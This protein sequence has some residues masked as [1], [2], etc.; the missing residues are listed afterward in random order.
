MTSPFSTV[1]TALVDMIA[2]AVPAD[3]AVDLGPPQSESGTIAVTLWSADPGVPEPQR[4]RRHIPG[5][6]TFVASID[7]VGTDGLDLLHE[8]W[9]AVDA[10]PFDL[11]AQGPPLAWWLAHGVAPRPHLTIHAQAAVERMLTPA[12]LVTEPLVLMNNH[13]VP[14]R[15]LQGTVL[16]PGAHPV[17]GASVVP[18]D[19]PALATTTNSAGGFLVRGMFDAET[20]DV[21][22]THYHLSARAA[23]P[24]DTA[25]FSIELSSSSS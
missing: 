11:A 2:A 14:V 20:I 15:I 5:H 6:L 8:L 24:V 17:G 12:P 13:D 16:G 18:V 7:R 4:H 23:V 9:L 22:F 19:S 3:L 25:D 1:A 21:D 10:G